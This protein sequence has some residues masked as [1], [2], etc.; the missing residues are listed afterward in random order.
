MSARSPS[1]RSSSPRAAGSD[2][3]VS[4]DSWTRRTVSS[5]SPKSGTGL[6]CLRLSRFACAPSLCLLGW[7]S[8]LFGHLR[9][10][11]H[12]VVPARSISR[13]PH[14]ALSLSGCPS[15]TSTVL[16]AWRNTSSETL[17]I[18]ACS[19]P[20]VPSAPRKMES[21]PTSSTLCEAQLRL[22]PF[23]D[24]YGASGVLCTLGPTPRSESQSPKR[25]LR[26]RALLG[27][28]EAE[29]SL[30]RR[31]KHPNHASGSVL[32]TRGSVESTSSR[33]FKQSPDRAKGNLTSCTGLPAR[34]SCSCWGRSGSPNLTRPRRC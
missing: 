6:R 5:K 30:W 7:I 24:G 16:F 9:Q 4:D 31:S 1:G 34:S 17:P 28:E 27:E 10:R 29:L 8:S 14:F 33:L 19:S 23:E 32:S 18:R 3:P 26:F 2:S 21:A 22:I 11:V 15:T 13:L 20:D 25:E 12:C